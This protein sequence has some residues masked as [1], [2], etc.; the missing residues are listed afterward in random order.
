[1]ILALAI[2]E[3]REAKKSLIKVT[4]EWRN[5]FVR[6]LLKKYKAARLEDRMNASTTYKEW[7][8]F[9]KQLDLLQGTN[10]YKFKVESRLYDYERIESRYRIMKQL[11]KSKNIK[12]L[13]HAL[14]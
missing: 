10:D 12:T 6:Y 4:K 13:A 11:R 14:R 7:E 9:A 2:A 8:Q 3:M 1:M 5:M